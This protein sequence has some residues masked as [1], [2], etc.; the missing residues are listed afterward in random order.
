[1]GAPMKAHQEAGGKGGNLFGEIDQGFVIHLGSGAMKGLGEG[2]VLPAEVGPPLCSGGS[3]LGAH[4]GLS[5]SRVKRAKPPID[6]LQ[7]VHTVNS[8]SSHALL[9]EQQEDKLNGAGRA[10]RAP[11][12]GRPKKNKEASSGFS[13]AGAGEARKTFVDT[14]RHCIPSAWSS[15]YLESTADQPPAGLV[16]RLPPP[17]AVG[18]QQAATAKIKFAIRGKQAANNNVVDRSSLA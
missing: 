14:P 4:P 2:Q 8:Q 15:E 6:A 16:I 7:D 11:I 12:G 9:S 3:G 1:M 5:G 18:A 17:A 10:E 13:F